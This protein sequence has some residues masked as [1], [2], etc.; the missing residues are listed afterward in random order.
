MAEASSIRVR[1]LDR[2]YSLRVK[3]NEDA[4]HT[5]EIAAYVDRRLKSFRTDHPDRP[6][7]TGAVITALALTEELF[8]A[9]R[10]L[11]SMEKDRES[12]AAELERM[13]AD[14]LDS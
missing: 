12:D 8:E 14:V 3:S 1:I 2:E 7:I 13:L 9:R 5:R 6:E 4:R 11:E 10:K